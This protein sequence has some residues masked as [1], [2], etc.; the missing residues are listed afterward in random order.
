[1]ILRKTLSHLRERGYYLQFRR[2]ATCL[3]CSELELWITPDGFLVDEQYRFE[4]VIPDGDR[5][6]YAISTIEGIKGFL[7]DT[8]F[9]YEDNI[10]VEMQRKLQE[11]GYSPAKVI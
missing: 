11:A 1:M 6:V 4:D 2:E 8:C 3:Y 10:S 5:T 7:V 9:V